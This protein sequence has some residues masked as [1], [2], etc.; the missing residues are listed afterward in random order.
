[1]PSKFPTT[2]ESPKHRELKKR[3]AAYLRAQGF[4]PR[5]I[6]YEYRLI[7]DIRVPQRKTTSFQAPAWFG[8]TLYVDVVA[9]DKGRRVAA[10]EVGECTREKLV[11]LTKYFPQV[12]WWP[13]GADEPIAFIPTEQ[14]KKWLNEQEEERRKDLQKLR[15]WIL[16]RLREEGP[17]EAERLEARW[18][19][20]E[21]AT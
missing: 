20:R 16:A 1:M 3:A 7:S 15:E 5:A 8:S 21:R 9:F 2:N 4:N 18:R 13:Y 14:D 6:R 10:V 11:V 12:F 19:K 17:K